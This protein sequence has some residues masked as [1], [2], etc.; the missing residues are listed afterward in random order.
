MSVVGRLGKLTAASFSHFAPGWLRFFTVDM[1]TPQLNQHAEMT[2]TLKTAHTDNNTMTP[3]GVEGCCYLMQ[4]WWVTA[5]SILDSGKPKNKAAKC[6]PCAFIQVYVHIMDEEGSRGCGWA[7]EDA[8]SG[9]MRG[10]YSCTAGG[11]EKDLTE[12]LNGETRQAS[13]NYK[14]RVWIRRRIRST[15][16]H[17]IRK[18][19]VRQ[20]EG[21]DFN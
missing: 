18:R 14:Q 9:E 15:M 3:S 20:W 16:E 1:L 2:N 21:A 4:E 6:F 17:G 10:R 12:W 19:K 11:D 5:H 13:L 8:T 7:E